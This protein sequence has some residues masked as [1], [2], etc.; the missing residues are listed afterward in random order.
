MKLVDLEKKID[1]RMGDIIGTRGL[2]LSISS[3]LA[4]RQAGPVEA[5]FHNRIATH[6]LGK[7]AIGGLYTEATVPRVREVDATKIRGAVVFVWRPRYELTHLAQIG[8][9]CGG[10]AAQ[11]A[12]AQVGKQYDTC[13]WHAL[14]GIGTQ[15]PGKWYCSELWAAALSSAGYSIPPEWRVSVFPWSMQQHAE[16]TGHILYRNYQPWWCRT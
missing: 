5:M 9:I 11:F 15:N 4:W 16:V 13:A 8:V 12:R 1:L 2:K 3:I 14:Y 10:S 6:I 7:S